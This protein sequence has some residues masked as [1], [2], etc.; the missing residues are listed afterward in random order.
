[1]RN[2]GEMT[3]EVLGHLRSF[4]RDQEMSTHLTANVSFGDLAIPVDDAGILTRGRIQIGDEL[5]WVDRPDRSAGTAV[6][7]PYG[8]GM[9]G[10]SAASHASI[11]KQ[12][13]W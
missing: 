4:V 8:R 12:S 2:F 6:I 7:P 11:S 10:T 3:D 1:M 9:D 5:I 13:P